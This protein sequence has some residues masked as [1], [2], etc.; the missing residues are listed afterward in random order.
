MIMK[1]PPAPD[2]KQMFRRRRVRCLS[3]RVILRYSTHSLANLQRYSVKWCVGKT[4]F[5]NATNERNR[6]NHVRA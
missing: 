1:E 6:A 2:D 4:T 3:Q 5:T